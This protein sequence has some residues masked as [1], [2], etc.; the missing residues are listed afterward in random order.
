MPSKVISLVAHYKLASAIVRVFS[1]ESS[2]NWLYGNFSSKYPYISS[3]LHNVQYTELI[4]QY[5]YVLMGLNFLSFLNNI[6]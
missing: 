1:L 6:E 4:F 2:I 3:P 5:Q